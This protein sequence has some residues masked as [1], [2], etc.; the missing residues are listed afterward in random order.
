M[1][2]EGFKR[3]LSNL[4]T[5]GLAVQKLVTDRHRQL[6][7]Y[8]REETPGIHHMYDVWHIAKG[9]D[10]FAEYFDVRHERHLCVLECVCIFTKGSE[11]R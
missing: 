3:M 6:A 11:W 4:A 10:K 7:K 9:E 8:V 5:K 1:E 2:L